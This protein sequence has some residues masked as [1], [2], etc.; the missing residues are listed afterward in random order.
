MFARSELLT[1]CNA[2]FVGALLRILRSILIGICVGEHGF[3]IEHE[4]APA[5]EAPALCRE[6]AVSPAFRDV[7][8]GAN[9]ERLIV[10]VGGIRLGYANHAGVIREIFLTSQQIWTCRRIHAIGE[11]RIEW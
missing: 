1:T 6:Y 4:Q 10:N 9:I 3:P 7:H 5:T 11:T 2:G 8:F